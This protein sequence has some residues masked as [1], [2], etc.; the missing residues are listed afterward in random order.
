M[1]MIAEHSRRLH[2]DLDFIVEQ[3]SDQLLYGS[4]LPQAPDRMNPAEE[5]PI[6][7]PGGIQQG[8]SRF[9]VHE[10]ELRCLSDSLIRMT[11]EL[12][13]LLDGSAG[14]SFSQNRL[15][16]FDLVSAGESGVG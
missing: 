1:S 4:E 5:R 16:F 13:E 3:Q 14:H 11:Q 7:V 9:Q 2:A 12:L 10:R 8:G 6:L 15:G